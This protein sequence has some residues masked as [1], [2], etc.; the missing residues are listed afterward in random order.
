[1]SPLFYFTMKLKN[2]LDNIPFDFSLYDPPEYPVKPSAR[3]L[4]R[5]DEIAKKSKKNYNRRRAQYKDWLKS[6][7]YYIANNALKH[8]Y[9]S[10]DDV[11]LYKDISRGFDKVLSLQEAFNEIKRYN[12][13][14]RKK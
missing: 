4:K 3:I 11:E 10:K 12:K 9:L 5:T 13:Q 8:K 6:A 14:E 7:K 2:P 1:M